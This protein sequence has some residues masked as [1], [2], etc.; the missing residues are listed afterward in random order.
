[1][2]KP[3]IIPIFLPNIG[4]PHRCVFCDQ[5]AIS[6]R[7][8]ALPAVSDVRDTVRAHLEYSHRPRGIIQI[9]FYGGNFLGLKPLQANPLLQ[10]AAHLVGDGSIDSIRFST[11]PDT[12][13]PGNLDMIAPYPVSTVELGAQSMNDRVLAGINR[14]HTAEH[15]RQAVALLKQRKYTIGLQMMTGLPGDTDDSAMETAMQIAA[16]S[17]DFVRI[18]PTVVLAGSSLADAYRGGEYVPMSLEA[19]VTLVKN[20]YRVF[21]QHHIPVIRMGLQASAVLDDPQAVLAGPYH[22]AFGHLVLSELY[23]DKAT[24][25]LAEAQTQQRRASLKVHPRN[26]SRVRGLKNRN[27]GILKKRFHLLSL[28]IVPDADLGDG[29]VIVSRED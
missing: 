17:P 27:I 19:T 2:R 21:N 7:P 29:R 26:T 28:D 11:R 14:G 10:E 4:C 5:R 22:P 12:I 20:L 25:A 9:S 16:L 3:L 8:R 18:Y 23:L 15:T 24:S 6:G 1:M 13:V